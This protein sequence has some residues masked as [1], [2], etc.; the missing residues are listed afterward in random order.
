[1]HFFR[2]ELWD[3]VFHRFALS[4]K[5]PLNCFAEFGR[6]NFWTRRQ[7]P[8]PTKFNY[9]QNILRIPCNTTINV[10]KASR[11]AYHQYHK[12]LTFS[13]ML[14]TK[15]IFT[16][17]NISTKPFR[18]YKAGGKLS[19]IFFLVMTGKV[20]GQWQKLYTDYL[21]TITIRPKCRTIL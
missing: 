13:Y 4:H 20:K 15:N 12:N 6:I 9:D 8:Q 21:V 14:K 18:H 1:M 7:L 19:P 3:N 2:A 16:R 10:M 17:K 11:N 5:K